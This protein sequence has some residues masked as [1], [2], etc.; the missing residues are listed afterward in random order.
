MARTRIE[1]RDLTAEEVLI[2]CLALEFE[3]DGPIHQSQLENRMKP[4]GCDEKFLLDSELLVVAQGKNE[5]PKQGWYFAGEHA[6]DTVRRQ[7]RKAIKSIDAR[8][9][10]R[11]KDP[12]IRQA[13]GDE[14]RECARLKRLQRRLASKA[15]RYAPLPASQRPAPAEEVEPDEPEIEEEL[16]DE[17]APPADDGYV[18]PDDPDAEAADRTDPPHSDDVAQTPPRGARVG[19][20]KKTTKKTQRRKP[21][22]RQ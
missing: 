1:T 16:I 14:D 12:H 21:K 13:Y 19:A 6:E 10:E 8:V 2:L 9:E 15:D 20:G 22:P 7:I 18:D 11:R 3:G 17:G 4:N 5:R